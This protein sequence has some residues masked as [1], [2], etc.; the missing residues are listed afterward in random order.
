MKSSPSNIRNC[1]ND[2]PGKSCIDTLRGAKYKV[3]APPKMI[4][5]RYYC[6]LEEI[7]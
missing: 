4:N 6:E 7:I 3:L 2:S 5:G 1:L